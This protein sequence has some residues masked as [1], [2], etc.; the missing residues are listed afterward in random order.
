LGCERRGGPLLPDELGMNDIDYTGSRALREALDKLEHENIQFA[1]ARVGSR[2]L[3]PGSK[4]PCRT[5]R[6]PFASMGEAVA[7]LGPRS[8]ET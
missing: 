2:W 3:G 4:R 1:M 8:A 7:A 6:R 5:H